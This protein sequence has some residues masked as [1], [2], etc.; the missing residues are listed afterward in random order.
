MNDNISNLQHDLDYALRAAFEIGLAHGAIGAEYIHH[1][2][3]NT[4][5]VAVGAVH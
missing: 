1:Y 5:G 2:L 4:L 3:T